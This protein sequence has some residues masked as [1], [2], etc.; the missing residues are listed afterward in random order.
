V[1]TASQARPQDS[2]A[3]LLAEIADLPEDAFVSPAH[4]AAMLGTS[5]NVLQNWRDQKRGPRFH[6]SRSFVRYRVSDLNSF[7]AQRADEIAA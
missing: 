5:T 2:R 4:A 3:S 6:G 7:M 1:S